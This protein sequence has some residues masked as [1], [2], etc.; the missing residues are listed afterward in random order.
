[1]Q[2]NIPERSRKLKVTNTKMN[3][4]SEGGDLVKNSEF[5]AK[6]TIQFYKFLQSRKI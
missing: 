3:F 6:A 2:M 1:M 4:E 5:K